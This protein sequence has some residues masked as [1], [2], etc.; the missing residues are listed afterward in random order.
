MIPATTPETQLAA[1]I[2]VK[3][4]TSPE[5]QAE[6]VR[7]SNYFPTRA[8]TAD[9]LG[10]YISE[11]PQWGQAFDL[12]HYGV[13]EPQLISYQGVR[14]AA[15]QAYQRDHAGRRHPDNPGRP[16]RRGQRTPDGA[17]GR[18][19]A[20]A[21]ADRSAGGRALRAGDRTARWPA[22]TRAARPS[23]GGTSTAAR[24]KRAWR[25]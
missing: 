12:L 2:F 23:S 3:W 24:A 21:R 9:F 25:Q 11:N 10:D 5:M 13:F 8:S 7:I 22:S 17:D 19:R 20:R 15:Q 6:W 16:H 1:W 18:H 14:D 4:L